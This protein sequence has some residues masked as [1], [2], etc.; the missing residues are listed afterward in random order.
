VKKY[1]FE[2][3]NTLYL[4]LLVTISTSVSL[5]FSIIMVL[6]SDVDAEILFLIQVSLM[7]V[8]IYALK[9]RSNQKVTAKL[10]N[11]SV[12]ITINNKVHDIDFKT[13]TKYKA[14]T[15]SWVRLKIE[16]LDKKIVLFVNDKVSDPKKAIKFFMDLDESIIQYKKQYKNNIAIDKPLIINSIGTTLIIS[17]SIFVAFSIIY[18]L[19]NNEMSIIKALS[20]ILGMSAWWLYYRFELQLYRSKLRDACANHAV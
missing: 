18:F 11:K 17:L 6:K 2:A 20:F 3:T 14:V 19:L 7:L 13:I 5:A 12:K 15:F 9:N 16:Y 4:F 8:P 1:H 10:G